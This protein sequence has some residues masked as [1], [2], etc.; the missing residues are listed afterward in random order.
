MRARELSELP[1]YLTMPAEIEVRTQALLQSLHAKL[2]KSWCLGLM[3]N[4]ARHVGQRRTTPERQR[5]GQPVGSLLPA[6]GTHTGRTLPAESGELKVVDFR[7]VGVDEVSGI[8][9]D[10]PRS[11]FRTQC[12]SQ[13]GDIAPQRDLGR[14]RRLSVP[15][16]LSELILPDGVTGMGQHPG[17]Q[18]PLP[19]P[20]DH[21]FLL[22]LRHMQRPE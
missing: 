4:L 22:A 21:V 20:G 11:G 19:G 12:A 8:A 3:E 13:P 5:L 16:E 17:Q 9:G 7:L 14:W 2:F 15:H 1:D 10:D 6:P 18:Y